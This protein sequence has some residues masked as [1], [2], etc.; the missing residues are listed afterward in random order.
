M[1]ELVWQ[2]SDSGALTYLTKRV[3]DIY[4]L[5]RDLVLADPALLAAAVH[6]AD[7]DLVA[8]AMASTDRRWQLEYRIVRP[9]GTI[10]WIDESAIKTDDGAGLVQSVT[11]SALDVTDRHHLQRT[12]TGRDAVLEA[13][14]STRS[15]GILVLDSDDRI[16]QASDPVAEIVGYAPEALVGTPLNVLLEHDPAAALLPPTGNRIQLD[17]RRLV[18]PDGIYR[19]VATELLPVAVVDDEG[20]ETAPARVAI[21]HDVT[22][23]RDISAD[24]AAREQFDQQTGLLTRTYFRSR[25]GELVG[26]NTEG[27]AVLWIDLDGFKEIND[28]FG[29]RS[30]DKVLATIAARLQR[31]ARRNDVLGRLGGDEFA[32]LITRIEDLDSVEMLVHRICSAVREPIDIDGTLAYVSA[33]VGIALHPQDGRTAEELLHNAD[34]AMYAA[35][36][37][38]R[39]RHAYFAAEMNDR[40]DER[41]ELRRELAGAVRAGEFELHYQ[42]VIEVASGRLVH[43]EALLRWRRG[44]ELVTA[45]AFIEHALD[46]GQL[47]AIGRLVLK[48]LDVDITD[49]YG[50]LG[51]RQPRVAVNLSG[52]ELEDRETA[53]WL[54]AWNPAG[55][56]ER[57][58]AEV[59]E[60][61][62][63]AQEGRAIHTLGV[64]R[65]LGATI[66]VDDFGTGYFELGDTRS[67]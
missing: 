36:H 59:T 9:D 65:R 22:R 40:A 43:V 12:A 31:A 5:A 48:M 57:V 25:T 15:V 60:S 23:L 24:L 54:L 66:S 1:R 47:R 39:D 55:G 14:L 20:G 8:A 42:P 64:L 32:M 26:A 10:R 46:S 49:L 11:G 13:L 3:E 38:G 4:G 33:S 29:H 27:L 63:L 52:S 16:V 17:A 21:V 56:F 35:K 53:D 45:D 62:L 58:I 6:P 50:Q 44:G 7:R 51:D 2:R 19:A 28:R 34:I 41:A 30:G 18:G 67:P 61:V 37:G